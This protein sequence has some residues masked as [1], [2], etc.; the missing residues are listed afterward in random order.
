MHV[1][2]MVVLYLGF[3][4]PL[5]ALAPTLFDR[6]NSPAAM[7][8][9]SF[10]DPAQ[11]NS[12]DF[13]G[14]PLG[15]FGRDSL[16]LRIDI[17]PQMIRWHAANQTDSL[18]RKYTAWQVPDLLVGVP[19]IF[20]IRTYYQPLTME[21]DFPA[22]GPEI[23]PSTILPL[24]TFGLTIAGQL[25]SGLMQFALQAKGFLGEGKSD[26]S[27]NTRLYWGC[28]DLSLSIGSRVHE[29]LAIGMNGGVQGQFDSLRNESMLPLP[30]RCFS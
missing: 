21:S 24:Q 9:P 13:F 7:A 20:Y 2:L 1:R 4:F 30:D 8:S 17:G 12:Y 18:V 23:V 10:S 25:P 19:C 14:S 3:S 15:L 27:Q 16:K 28:D 22:S 6:S 5:F 29:L 11:Y 26:A